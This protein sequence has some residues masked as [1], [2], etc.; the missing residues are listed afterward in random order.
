VLLPSLLWASLP[1]FAIVAAAA[2]GL[3]RRS[4]GV[5]VLAACALGVLMSLA[6]SSYVARGGDGL[7]S[8]RSRAASLRGALHC[9]LHLERADDACL[10][11]ILD[12]Y[13]QMVRRLAPRLA[14]RRIGPFAD[15]RPRARVL[16]L[17]PRPSGRPGA[18]AGRRRRRRR[19]AVTS[20]PA[21]G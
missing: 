19:P 9:V 7:S 8:T 12:A 10:R 17:S 21:R 15:H 2:A 14:R 16:Q 20:S 13:P 4:R 3:P 6:G 18:R 11:R 1:A 5:R